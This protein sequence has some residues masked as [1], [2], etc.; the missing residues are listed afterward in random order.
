VYAML[1]LNVC[2]PQKINTLLVI[3]CYKP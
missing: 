3:F 1:A 2:M